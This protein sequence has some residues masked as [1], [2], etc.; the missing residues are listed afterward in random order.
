MEKLFWG[1]LENNKLTHVEQVELPGT[2]LYTG[3]PGDLVQTIAYSG[4]NASPA[5]VPWGPVGIPVLKFDSS[6]YGTPLSVEV[7]YS[8]AISAGLK[9]ENVN[10]PALTAVISIAG[11][12]SFYWP[13]SN[14]IDTLTTTVPTSVSLP[15]YDGTLDYDG[16]S[17]ATFPVTGSSSAS[18]TI[19]SSSPEWASLI[20]SGG[21]TFNSDGA[22]NVHVTTVVSDNEPAVD[23]ESQ[24]VEVS[25]GMIWHYHPLPG[26]WVFAIADEA[27][28]EPLTFSI[29]MASLAELGGAGAGRGETNGFGWQ[30]VEDFHGH[31]FKVFRSKEQ[32]ATGDGEVTVT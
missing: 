1:G 4:I 32:V 26:F 2:Y 19:T 16:T 27:P 30:Q 14:P 25:V 23:I 24:T 21:V 29:D 9:V 6:I 7:V 20:G 22:A 31:L 8:L 15:T 10:I 3:I 18:E 12:G 13:S 17:G 28:W 5:D 11:D